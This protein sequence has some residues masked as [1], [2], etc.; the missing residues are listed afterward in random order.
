MNVGAWWQARYS[1]PLLVGVPLL[2][3]T[4]LRWSLGRLAAAAIALGTVAT[5]VLVIV[6]YVG[7]FR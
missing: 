6:W 4:G 1:M 7:R 5:Q 3:V 2:L